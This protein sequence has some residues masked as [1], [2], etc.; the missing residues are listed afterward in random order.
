[1]PDKAQRS[2]LLSELRQLGI[3]HNQ[4]QIL[5]IA[6]KLDGTIIF[7]ETG[8]SL[9]GLQHILENHGSDFLRRR[10]LREQIPDLIIDAVVIGKAIGI[11]GTGRTI[12][13]IMFNGEF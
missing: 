2:L 10:I 5:K 9:S 8:T 6:K 12:Y 13:E 11:Q 3:K 4:D 7:L 1:M